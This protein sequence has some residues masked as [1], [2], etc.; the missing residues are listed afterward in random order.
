MGLSEGD[1]VTAHDA[2]EQRVRLEIAR[3][4]DDND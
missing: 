1:R 3:D 2:G 4:G